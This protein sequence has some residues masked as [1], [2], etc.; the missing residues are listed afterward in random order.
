M[1]SFK[2]AV[3]EAAPATGFPV[4]VSRIRRIA[5][6]C[7]KCMAGVTA[8]VARTPRQKDRL[9]A[10]LK[11]FRSPKTAFAGFAAPP[12]LVLLADGAP[13]PLED[14]LHGLGL[15]GDIFV[16]GFKVGLGHDN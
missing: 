1:R 11:K 4:A 13:H 14:A 6:A 2:P 5:L 3:L 9:H 12:V 10:R 16:H 7:R 15:R 8:G